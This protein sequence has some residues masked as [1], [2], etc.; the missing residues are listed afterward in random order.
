MESRALKHG[1]HSCLDERAS[2]SQK[3]MNFLVEGEGPETYFLT[4]LMGLTVD[5]E[6]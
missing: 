6:R 2:R 4:D 3:K 5:I 1:L